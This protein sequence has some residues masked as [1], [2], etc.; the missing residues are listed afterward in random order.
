[1][2]TF[3]SVRRRRRRRKNK[4]EKKNYGEIVETKMHGG[5]WYF[6]DDSNEYHETRKRHVQNTDAWLRRTLPVLAMINPKQSFIS[7]GE[8]FVVQQHCVFLGRYASLS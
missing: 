7:V 6:A 4:K 8:M 1:M 5:C 2:R 3:L